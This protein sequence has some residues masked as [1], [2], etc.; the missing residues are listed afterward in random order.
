MISHCVDACVARLAASD[1][2]RSKR[3]IARL[4]RVVDSAPKSTR[5]WRE[6]GERIALGDDAAA[7]PDGSGYLLFAAEG[8]LPE[9]LDG[10][11]YFAGWSSVMVNVNDIA[12][13]GGAPMAV[14]DVYC[15]SPSSAAEAVVSGIR[16]ACSAYGVPLV[17]GHTT[18]R[19][20]GPHALAVAILGR[21][22]HLLTSFGARVG[23]VILFAVDLRGSYRGDF[24]FWN[25]T[26]GRSAESLRADLAVFGK[27]AAAGGV[28][29]C[30]DVSN[31]GI[32]GTLLMLLETSGVGALLDLDR[33]PRPSG[34]ELDRWLLSF[35]SYGF[36]LSATPEDAPSVQTSVQERG[37]ACEAVG[38][39]EDSSELWLASR[40]ERALLWDLAR[41]PFTGFGAVRRSVPHSGGE[42]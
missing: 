35:P 18:C 3:D 24:P 16:D 39:V 40:G 29:A 30:K 14:V 22:E 2:F 26:A 31:A 36:L 33:V 9:F 12:A 42:T 19:E 13:M 6:Q 1:A 17:G 8:I 10:D 41:R 11:P 32:A 38:R 34:V 15:H 5:D 21:A 20:S 37:L 28:R 7:I 4:A 23:D 25:A 27:L